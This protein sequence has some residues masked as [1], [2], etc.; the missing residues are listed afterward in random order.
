MP[1]APSVI[2][3]G[4]TTQPASLTIEAGSNVTFTAMAIGVPDPA[5]Q[6][7]FKG[8]NISGATSSSFTTNNVSTNTTG[9]FTVVATNTSGSATSVVAHLEVYSTQRAQLSDFGYLTNTYHS[10]VSGITGANYVVEAS[11]NLINWS[12]IQTNQTTFTNYDRSVTNYPYRFYRALYK[13]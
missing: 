5:Y 3:P 11:T 13:P 7:R 2:A 12:P 8:T 1:A 10:V 9:D 6:W 4:I